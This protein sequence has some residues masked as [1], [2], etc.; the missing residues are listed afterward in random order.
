[1]PFSRGFD[2]FEGLARICREHDLEKHVEQYVA[3]YQKA[4][5][6]AA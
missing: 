2:L 4:I 5:D 1:M 3:C 6:D